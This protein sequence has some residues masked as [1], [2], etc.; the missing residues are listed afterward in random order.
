MESHDRTR[1]RG[2]MDRPEGTPLA[3]GRRWNVN[4]LQ[5]PHMLGLAGPRQRPEL[6][7]PQRAV[8]VHYY[9]LVFY[10]PGIAPRPFPLQEYK[11]MISDKV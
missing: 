4:R 10:R 7:R 5:R 6:D 9:P 3:T 2:D 11:C 1:R 8:T